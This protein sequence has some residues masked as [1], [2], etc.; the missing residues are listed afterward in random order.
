MRKKTMGGG[1]TLIELLVVIAI[2]A[3]LAAILFPVFSKAREKA[4]QTTC[5][6]NQKQI[7]TAVMMYV[8]ENEETLPPADGW[9]S[10]IDVGGKILKCPN[11]KDA[12]GYV[13]SVH[14]T[15]KKIGDL[16][17]PV[18]V[19]LTADGKHAATAAVVGP[20]AEEATFDHVGYAAK[21]FALTR[22]ANKMAI[23]SYVDGH[24]NT[25]TS[26]PGLPEELVD[27]AIVGSTDGT[28]AKFLSAETPGTFNVEGTGYWG[29]PLVLNYQIEGD[30][31]IEWSFGNMSSGHNFTV[32]VALQAEA[33]NGYYNLYN[34]KFNND[35]AGFRSAGAG[36][37]GGDA[38]TAVG[39]INVPKESTFRIE[40]KGK[41]II[42][43]S[44]GQTYTD[45]TEST[46]ILRPKIYVHYSGASNSVTFAD[47]AIAGYTIVP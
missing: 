11:T 16:R 19:V 26:A 33:H 3:I 28:S 2:I 46:G 21:D 17:V 31:Y 37:N 25:I 24:V 23:A 38:C 12:V 29:S 34:L 6:S 5:T 15:S 41:K 35:G 32:A 20:P 36:V 44:G 10:A 7:A 47:F 39:S 40:R 1:F 30:G 4:R 27:I 8:Q 9:I 42:Y 45:P 43:T 13:M 18:D 14:A 22:H